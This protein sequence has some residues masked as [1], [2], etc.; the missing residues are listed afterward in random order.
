MLFS[1]LSLCE[2]AGSSFKAKWPSL[3]SYPVLSCES[4]KVGAERIYG[5]SAA[6]WSGRERP[7]PGWG[8]LNASSCSAGSWLCI[9][10]RKTQH[11]SERWRVE[12]LKMNAFNSKGKKNVFFPRK[13]CFLLFFPIS[14][15]ATV[16]HTLK[17]VW[18]P[19][20]PTSTVLWTSIALVSL[21]LLI[22]EYL[23]ALAYPTPAL[24]NACGSD[25][26]ETRTV[27]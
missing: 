27:F 20:C 2:T 14:N 26:R 3:I 10:K 21:W 24:N 16:V 5:S 8:L 25:R 7:D 11:C 23:E 1:S 19:H 17:G 13:L 9:A 12:Q 18:T 6:P 22:L 4:Q 15:R